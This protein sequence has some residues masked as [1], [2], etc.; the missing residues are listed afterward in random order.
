MLMIYWGSREELFSKNC[1]DIGGGEGFRKRQSTKVKK[2]AVAQQ[3]CFHPAV[4]KICETVQCGEL[5]QVG[6]LEVSFR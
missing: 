4:M 1:R 2:V 3:L 5:G 6:Y